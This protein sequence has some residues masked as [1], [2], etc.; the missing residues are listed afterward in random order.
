MPSR[1]LRAS[2]AA[3]GRGAGP[4]GGDRRR[5]DRPRPDHARDLGRIDL[6]LHARARVGN[7]ERRPRAR[8]RA[9]GPGRAGGGDPPRALAR[10]RPQSPGYAQPGGPQPADVVRRELQTLVRE[11]Q[12]S[13]RFYGSQPGATPVRGLVV[14][15]SLVDLPGFAKRLGS[16]LWMPVSPADPFSRVE[17]GAGRRP[18]GAHRRARRRGRP[19]DR[20]LR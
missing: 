13:I 2:I 18:A 10:A 1:V 15:G 8:A 3:A 4:R 16:D 19:R 9:Q 17:L 20:G 7:G 11:L 12:S 6:P 5:L 14:S